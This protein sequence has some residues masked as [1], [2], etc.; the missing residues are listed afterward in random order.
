MGWSSRACRSP[1]A[2][3]RPP[4]CLGSFTT[5][6]SNTTPKLTKSQRYH[7]RRLYIAQARPSW[8]W[9]TIGHSRPRVSTVL[10]GSNRLVLILSAACRIGPFEV[11]SAL[12]EHRSVVKSTVVGKPDSIRGEIVRSG[13]VRATPGCF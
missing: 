3:L 9:R 11:E 4:T 2:T 8:W 13:F 12:L 5:G 6:S 1:S 7:I 10:M